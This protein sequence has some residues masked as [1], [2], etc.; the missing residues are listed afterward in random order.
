ME[1]K[2]LIFIPLAL[3][4]MSAKGCQTIEGRAL[5]AAQAKGQTVA[6]VDYPPLPEA[7]IAHVERVK[8]KVGEKFRWIQNRWEV[9][10][11]NRDRKADDCAA[12]GRDMQTKF[13]KR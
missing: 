1:W 13:G 5:E 8:P 6:A 11:D 10:A 12:W 9:T 7:C 2:A 3:L 4:L